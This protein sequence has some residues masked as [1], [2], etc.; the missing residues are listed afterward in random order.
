MRAILPIVTILMT[1]AGCA[2][3]DRYDL[4]VRGAKVIDGSGGPQIPADIGVRHG[5]IAAVGDLSGASAKRFILAPGL[6]AAPGFIDVHTHIDEDILRFGLAENFVRDGVTT[7]IYGNCGASVIDVADHF[8]Q[9]R[10]KGSAVNVATL[11]GHN[12][13]LRQVKGDRAGDLN[14]AQLR[15]ARQLIRRGMR[16]GALGM[17]TGLIYTPGSYSKTEEII[18]LQKV[19]AEFGGIYVTHI[20]SEGDAILPAIN[21]AIAIARSARC[22][23]HIS[24][25]KLPADIAR[26]IGGARAVI[27]CIEKARAAG[28]TIGVDQ[29]PYT[30]SSTSISTLIPDELLTD[31]STALR[32]R[33]KDAAYFIQAV[34]QMRKYHELDRGRKH[35][36]YVAIASSAGF[37][38][39]NGMNLLQIAQARNSS[40]ELL[41][42]HSHTPVSMADQCRAALELFAAGDT[43][44]VFHT[45]AEPEVESFMRWP[46]VA[47]ASDSGMRQ[48]GVGVPHPR[49]YGTNARV[50]GRYARDRGLFSIEEAVRRMTSLPAGSFGLRDRGL[51][52]PGYAADITLFDPAM[53]ID[54]ATYEK[55]HQ[56]PLGF[57]CVIVNGEV[58]FESGHMTGRRPG[59]VL[60]RQATK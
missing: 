31:G 4:I 22:P 24:H 29:Y 43:S 46:L 1:V 47:V 48:F 8:R 38:R 42:D 56:Y 26:T 7:V 50:L 3:A 12:T 55:P 37:P 45:M 57:A 15:E 10:Q 44:C 49:G 53:V 18:E 20:R 33:L 58:V 19:A 39:Y 30:A 23:L 9:V 54:Q 52:R 5:Q 51:L 35:L 16:A 36:G 40:A 32:Q 25:V 34:E 14:P 28:L 11:V 2:P 59:A 60:T 17:S 27:N 21:E 13:V 41:R 6:V